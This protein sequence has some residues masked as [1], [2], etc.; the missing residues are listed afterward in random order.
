MGMYLNIHGLICSLSINYE[1]GDRKLSDHKSQLCPREGR[2]L[3]KSYR[4]EIRTVGKSWPYRTP[5]RRSQ[6]IGSIR[7][8]KELQK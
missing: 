2:A 3:P 8:F 5:G 6:D 4:T 1:I 7:K